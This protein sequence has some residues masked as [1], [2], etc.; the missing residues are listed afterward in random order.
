M[1]PD[2]AALAGTLG[3]GAEALLRALT[4]RDAI[5]LRLDHIFVYASLRKDS[6]STDPTGQALRSRASALLTRISAA[7][8]FLE[9]EILTI[10]DETIARWR[11]EQPELDRYAFYLETLARQR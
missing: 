6:D 11:G 2:M 7:L 3:D 1:L 10:P 8:A 5:E 9:P 4:M